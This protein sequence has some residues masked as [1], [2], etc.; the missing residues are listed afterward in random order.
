MKHRTFKRNQKQENRPSLDILIGVVSDRILLAMA[1]ASAAFDK[2]KVRHALVG[3]LAVGAHGYPRATKDV[4]FLVGNEAFKHHAGGLVT[5]APG[6]PIQSGDVAVDPLSISP[7]E[8][9]LEEAL[10][11][12]IVR[13]GIPIVTLE[14]L[15]YMKLKSPRNKDRTDL[16]EL[17]KTGIPVRQITDYLKE[18]APQLL[19]KFEEI[20]LT[21]NS[22][23]MDD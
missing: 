1:N 19:P 3:G 2:A 21:A 18:N 8:L 15:V 4:D 16:I 11:H 17:A 22:E 10:D 7:D 9:F 23:D 12:A 20:V 5:F 14:A 6:V 13:N